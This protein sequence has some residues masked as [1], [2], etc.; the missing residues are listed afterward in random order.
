MSKAYLR[1]A[2]MPAVTGIM[3][4]S[5]SFKRF[6]SR[7]IGS[8]TLRYISLIYSGLLTVLHTL[9]GPGSSVGIATE[10]RAGRPGDRIPVGRDF[11]PVQTGSGAH[12]ASCTIGTGS[13]PGVKCGWGVLLTTH[14]L[15]MP[16]SRKGRAILLPTLEAIQA[17]NGR[18]L[19]TLYI[20]TA[21]LLRKM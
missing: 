1:Q 11:P 13:F 6:W 15:L 5:F 3:S 8:D 20:R 14:P 19:H 16:R 21:W 12:P 10:L 7:I 9:Y 4:G 18:T 2:F 17:C